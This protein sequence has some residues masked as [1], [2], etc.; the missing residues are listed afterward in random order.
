MTAGGVVLGKVTVARKHA[1]RGQ[2]VEKKSR[3]TIPTV[4]D[5]QVDIWLSNMT[6]NWPGIAH[7]TSCMYVILAG[8]VYIGTMAYHG[9][10]TIETNPTYTSIQTQSPHIP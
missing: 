9:L 5:N 4:K 6:Y 3:H 7:V 8:A 10:V 2:D 1:R